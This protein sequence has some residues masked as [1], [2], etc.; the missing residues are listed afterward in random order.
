LA[1]ALTAGEKPW[2]LKITRAPRAS[3]S[4]STKIAPACE[5]FYQRAGL[6][7]LFAK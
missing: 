6:N 2:A 4:S 3:L 7:N 5:A 1:S